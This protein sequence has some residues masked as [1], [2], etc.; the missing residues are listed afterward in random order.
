MD[1]TLM[2]IETTDPLGF[3]HKSLLFSYEKQ[4]NYNSMNRY[5]LLMRTMRRG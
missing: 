1:I 2:L 3:K 5:A 4:N